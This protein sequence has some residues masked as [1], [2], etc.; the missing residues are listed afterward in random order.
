MKV[1]L[2]KVKLRFP[3]LFWTI[4]SHAWER[5]RTISITFDKVHVNNKMV[6]ILKQKECEIC[7]NCVNFIGH[8]IGVE[9]LELFCRMIDTVCRVDLQTN[10]GNLCSCFDSGDIFQSFESNSGLVP[11]GLVRGFLRSAADLY[12]INNRPHYSLSRPNGKL[13]KVIIQALLHFQ[14]ASILC[15]EASGKQAGCAFLERQPNG[16]D[17][18]G[19]GVVNLLSTLITTW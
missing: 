2:K 5:Q 3:L 15:P 7:T 12:L 9:P 8:I 19:L 6:I 18:P 10:V 1:L 14:G 16:S 4:L 17:W 11:P 13:V